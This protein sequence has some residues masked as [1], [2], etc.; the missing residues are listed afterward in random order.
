MVVNVSRPIE[1]TRSE[2]AALAYLDQNCPRNPL[3]GSV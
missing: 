1:P 3:V 2:I